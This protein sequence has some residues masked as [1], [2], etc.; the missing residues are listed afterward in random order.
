MKKQ[1]AKR[2]AN[3]SDGKNKDAS[4]GAKS[5]FFNGYDLKAL[6][7]PREAW[8]SSQKQHHGKF[9]YTVSNQ[10][11]GSVPFSET[12]HVAFVCSKF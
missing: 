9:S 12:K 5:H 3:A 4:A 7:V 6:G 10:E 8:P 2:A 11:S 1:K